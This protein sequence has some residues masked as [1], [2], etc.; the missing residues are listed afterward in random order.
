MA[1]R[2]SKTVPAAGADCST[3]GASTPDITAVSHRQTKSPS[4]S[5]NKK[6]KQR[7]NYYYYVLKNSIATPL[8]PPFSFLRQF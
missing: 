8:P 4:H 6:N 7:L 3:G 5:N 2:N 1:F